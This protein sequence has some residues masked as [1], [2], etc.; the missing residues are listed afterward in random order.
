MKNQTQLYIEQL[1]H[2]QK[3]DGTVSQLHVLQLMA[4]VLVY[5]LEQQKQI[6]ALDFGK[7]YDAK[8][9]D[10]SKLDVVATT[11]GKV[12]IETN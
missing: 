8:L 3:M 6:S 7:L 2:V 10:G 11:D 12:T 9:V 1:Q 5:L 4:Q